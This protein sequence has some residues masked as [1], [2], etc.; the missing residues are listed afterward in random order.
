MGLLS[1]TKLANCVVSYTQLKL[2]LFLRPS[3]QAVKQE[4]TTYGCSLADALGKMQCFAQV[5]L[6]PGCLLHKNLKV[7]GP[8]Y[9]GCTLRVRS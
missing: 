6:S 3:T 8:S 1:S 4:S 2:F 5:K 9:P 7:I